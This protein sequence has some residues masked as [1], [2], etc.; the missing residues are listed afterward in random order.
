MKNINGFNE[1]LSNMMN[2]IF[3]GLDVTAE[4]LN[5]MQEH[6]NNSTY[7]RL[8]ITRAWRDSSNV[9]CVAYDNDNWYHYNSKGEWY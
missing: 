9:L 1:S 2:E 8:H 6:W 3:T 7:S 5:T 4:E